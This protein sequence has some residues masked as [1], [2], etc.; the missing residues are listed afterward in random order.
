MIHT[1]ETLLGLPPMNN[2]DA[3]AAV[4]SPLFTGAGDQPAFKAEY[5][6]RDNGMIYQANAKNAPGSKESA[7]LDF[8]I[9][10][11]ADTEILNAILWRASKGNA[12]MPEPQHTVFPVSPGEK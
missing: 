1:M 12:A 7:A 6:N 5:R 4:I 9:A 11:A 8:S 10:D 2:N 3:R